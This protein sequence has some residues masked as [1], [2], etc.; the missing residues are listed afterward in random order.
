MIMCFELRSIHGRIRSFSI[1]FDRYS[2]YTVVAITVRFDRSYGMRYRH[3]H[4]KYRTWWDLRV[5][6]VQTCVS[7]TR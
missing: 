1:C 6:C 3:G 5:P 7:I 4:G 2:V